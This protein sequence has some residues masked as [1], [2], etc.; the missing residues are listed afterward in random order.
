MAIQAS[1]WLDMATNWT[2]HTDPSK[3]NQI[4][5]EHKGKS[6]LALHI[7]VHGQTRVRNLFY[8]FSFTYSK[9]EL[10]THISLEWYQKFTVVKLIGMNPESKLQG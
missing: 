8:L 6:L 1:K 9:V 3:V 10:K 4:N 7:N 5:I 2:I